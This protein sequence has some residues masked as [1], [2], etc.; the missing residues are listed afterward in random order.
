MRDVSF[1]E[2][3]D[4]WLFS[5][6]SI[7]RGIG[8]FSRDLGSLELGNWVQSWIEEHGLCNNLPTVSELMICTQNVVI[9]RRAVDRLIV[10]SK[11]ML[12]DGML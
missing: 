3:Y 11:G 10:Q 7:S 4:L 5:K 1:F 2:C 12:F 6:W 8:S 9:W